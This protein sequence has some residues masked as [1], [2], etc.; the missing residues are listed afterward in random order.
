MT[1]DRRGYPVV[2]VREGYGAWVPTY[3]DTVEDLMDRGLLERID[4]VDWTSLSSVCDLGC[5]T[6]RTGEWL[7]SKGIR[8]IDGVDLTAEMLAVARERGHH[9]ELREA[10]VCATGFEPGYD[11]AIS[12]LVDEHL[13]DLAPFYREAARLAPKFVLVGFHP[14]FMTVTGM[15]THFDHPTRGPLTIE[16]HLHLFQDQV[17]AARAAGLRLVE[18]HESVVDDEWVE[19]KPKWERWRGVPVSFAAVWARE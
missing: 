8:D 17:A 10:D 7:A 13:P 5:G 1:F 4:S 11:L 6:G 14:S 15:P 16:T 9:R 18:I 2:G 12:C 19:L 3:E